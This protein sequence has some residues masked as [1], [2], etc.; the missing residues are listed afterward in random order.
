MIL[1]ISE[2]CV[3]ETALDIESFRVRFWAPRN[4]D[5]TQS[6]VAV[7]KILTPATD[8][9]NQHLTVRG[10]NTPTLQGCGRKT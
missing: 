6:T 3:A 10:F 4:A 8:R 9:T 1:G 2:S 7:V 5:I